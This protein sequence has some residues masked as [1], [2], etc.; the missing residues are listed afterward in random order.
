MLTLMEYLD[1]PVQVDTN[2]IIGCLFI[3]SLYLLY[4]IDK[5]NLITGIYYPT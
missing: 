1:T 3:F 4:R 5:E 2:L